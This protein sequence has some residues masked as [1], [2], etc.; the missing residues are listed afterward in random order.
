MASVNGAT[1]RWHLESVAIESQNPKQRSEALPNGRAYR[2]LPRFESAPS[3]MRKLREENARLR[4]QLAY[5]VKA[6]FASHSLD[7]SSDN[8]VLTNSF[9][10]TKGNATPSVLASVTNASAPNA[11]IALFRKLF[12]GR[13]DVHAVRWT[14]RNGRSGYSPA[15][16][17][18]AMSRF[19]SLDKKNRKYFPLTDEVIRDHLLGKHTVGSRP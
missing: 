1:A 14:G 11:K 12:R 13:E 16:A 2:S 6:S 3:R 10:P 5:R 4:K 18:D 8:S 15:A 7:T 17:R 19:K 9:E